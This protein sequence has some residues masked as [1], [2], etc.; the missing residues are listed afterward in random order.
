ME[1]CSC[2]KLPFVL[3]KTYRKING[4]SEFSFFSLTTFFRTI[5]RYGD[6]EGLVRGSK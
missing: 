2:R 3:V 5:T 1:T 6:S 4:Q